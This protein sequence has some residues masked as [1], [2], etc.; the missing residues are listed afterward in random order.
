MIEI[1]G[2]PKEHVEKIIGDL[3]DG[4]KKKFKVNDMDIADAKE[5]NN[6]WTSFMDAEME[7]TE[8]KDL[9]GFS[10]NF[11]PTSIEVIEPEEVKMDGVEMQE[12]L[13]DILLNLHKFNMQINKFVLQNKYLNAE[14]K[15]AGVE[16]GKK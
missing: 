1:A 12:F 7:F 4:L 11:M 3:G 14:L 9:V 16:L 2:H 15:K 6:M 13:N 8:W 10:I 5:K